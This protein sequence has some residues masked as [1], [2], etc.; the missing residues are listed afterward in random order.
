M[1][2]LAAP[3]AEAVPAIAEYLASKERDLGR[4]ACFG[5]R[6]LGPAGVALLPALEAPLADDGCDDSAAQAIAEIDP[7]AFGA[8]GLYRFAA[9]VRSMM[10]RSCASS[11]ASRGP[12]SPV[13]L[14][15][16]R[17]RGR[18][19]LRPRAVA[20]RAAGSAGRRRDAREPR[21]RVER[22]GEALRLYGTPAVDAH[23]GRRAGVSAPT[24]ERIGWML[25]AL[26]R[27]VSA[28]EPIASGTT[29]SSAGASTLLSAAPST[30]TPTRCASNR[31]PT[32]RS[33][34]R[35]SIAPSAC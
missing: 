22:A 4:V 31:R 8:S 5:A 30:C 7:P 34:S 21:L 29:P 15:G 26:P 27:P 1:E 18:R 16:A 3:G 20:P 10:S 28:A 33:N 13:A 35:R 24:R 19:A 14:R 9:A 11:R 6:C 12:R 2:A 23:T 17:R 25:D 32:R